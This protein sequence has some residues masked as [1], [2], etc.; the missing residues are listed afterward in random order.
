MVVVGLD[1]LFFCC[2][3]STRFSAFAAM[4]ASPELQ[5]Q[6]S[7]KG[8]LRIAGTAKIGIYKSYPEFATQ[9]ICLMVVVGMDGLFYCCDVSTQVFGFCSYVGQS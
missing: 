2:D 4:L 3:V 7:F 6:D 8:T 5:T 1:G 9:D